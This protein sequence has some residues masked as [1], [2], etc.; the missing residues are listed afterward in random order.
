M[1]NTLQS[2]KRFPNKEDIL[3]EHIV[4]TY[5]YQKKPA[6]Q[7]QTP[8]KNTKILWICIIIAC[9]IVAGLAFFAAIYY[10]NGHQTTI[11]KANASASR[12]IAFTRGGSLNKTIIKNADFNGYAKGK[13]TLSNS[14]IML[15]NSGRSTWSNFSMD[16]QFP[17]SFSKTAITL[18]LKSDIGGEK[19]NIVLKDSRNKSSRSRDIFL[20]SNWRDETISLNTLRNDIDLSSINQMRIECDYVGEPSQ[21]A[22]RSPDITI[23]IKNMELIKEASL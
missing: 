8:V 9:S 22:K 10:L 1:S 18:S 11:A 23:Y 4:D 14:C 5:F 12:I 13:G 20:T 16:F 19:I 7:P 17:L 6:V 2:I 15:K 21:G 3:N